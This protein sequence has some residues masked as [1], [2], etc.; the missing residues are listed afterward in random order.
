MDVDIVR[1]LVNRMLDAANRE[2]SLTESLARE[3]ERGF[4]S[5]YCG[6]KFYIKREPRVSVSSES[7]SAIARE[8]LD[9]RPVEKIIKHHGI[10]RATL[11]RLLKR[12]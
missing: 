12:I 7:Q 10:S 8:Y 6:E 2:G 4:R 9:G 1:E 11:Y 3:V 5:E